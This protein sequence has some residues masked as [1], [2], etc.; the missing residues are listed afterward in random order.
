MSIDKVCLLPRSVLVDVNEQRLRLLGQSTIGMSDV[1]ITN[2]TAGAIDTS[3]TGGDA[4]TNGMVGAT[5]TM[6]MSTAVS[7]FITNSCLPKDPTG[8]RNGHC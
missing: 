6:D 2:D 1:V 5:E 8:T 4:V 7:A 3:D